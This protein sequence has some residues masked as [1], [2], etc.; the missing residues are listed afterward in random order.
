ME[1]NNWYSA[2]ADRC[3]KQTKMKRWTKDLRAL[4]NFTHALLLQHFDVEGENYGSRRKKLGYRLFN[5]ETC[6][7]KLFNADVMKGSE[8]HFLIKACVS[9]SMKK[10]VYI[11]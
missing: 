10:K 5:G 11:V 1:N 4:P 3:S 9:A 2:D 6:E 7:E 8:A